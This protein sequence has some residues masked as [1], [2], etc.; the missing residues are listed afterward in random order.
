MDQPRIQLVGTRVEGIATPWSFVDLLPDSGASAVSF[1]SA[2]WDPLTLERARDAAH[3]VDGKARVLLWTA[4]ST[5]KG[6][7]AARTLSALDELDVWF[8]DP[9][10]EGGIFHVKL[11][12]SQDA[13]GR[14]LCALLGSANFTDAGLRSN[15]ELGVV[16]RDEPQVLQDLRTWFD[17]QLIDAKPASKMDWGEAIRQGPERSE[18]A[19]RRKTFAAAKLAAPARAGDIASPIRQRAVVLGELADI[20]AAATGLPV[21]PNPDGVFVELEDIDAKSVKRA[22]LGERGDKLVV[23]LWPAELSGQ[24][25]EFY[26]TD[27]ANR[28]LQAVDGGT[29][30]ARLAPHLAFSKSALRER[31][32]YPLP[33]GIT[34]G[35]YIERWRANPEL[36]RQTSAD[37][38]LAERWAQLQRAGLAVD[39]PDGI[40]RH[41]ANRRAQGFPVQVR[42]G[43]EI[44]REVDRE[45]D[46]VSAVRAA[47]A[48]ALHMLREPGLPAR[49]SGAAEQLL[50]AMKAR[51]TSAAAAVK[52]FLN[53]PEVA[54]LQLDHQIPR[55]GKSYYIALSATRN[56]LYLNVVGNGLKVEL[57]ALTADEIREITNLE[58]KPHKRW[59]YVYLEREEHVQPI[60]GAL[61]ASLA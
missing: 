19:E 14:W 44:S 59:G 34:L 18:A 54:A 36:R 15:I 60:L 43:L 32:W 31:Y 23:R 35:Q 51:N 37:E 30:R 10:E 8:V 39:D 38:F 24:A 16:I 55:V 61:R 46:T 56:V 53:A 13:S 17:S 45:S 20:L 49:R 5:K 21:T 47:I 50:E 33:D 57:P 42:A 28:L 25:D 6:W 27:R 1:A 26:D 22:H 4:G 58:T 48:D 40:S 52:Q 7:E 11:A 2:Y 12:G 9:P 3:A 29:W 41:F